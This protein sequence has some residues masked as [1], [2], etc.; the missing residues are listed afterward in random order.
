MLTSRKNPPDEAR[1]AGSGRPH[2]PQRGTEQVDLAELAGPDPLGRRDPVGVEPAVEADLERHA[3]RGDRGESVHSGR[4]V[5]RDRLLAEHR[6]A[7]AGGPG[8][9]LGVRAGRGGDDD[10]VHVGQ[11]RVEVRQRRHAGLAPTAAATAGSAS[12]TATSS[13]DGQCRARFAA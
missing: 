1:N 5:Q 4:S 12:V 11:Q 6:P 7:G 9:Q 3:G 2:V 8:D 10:G 13:A